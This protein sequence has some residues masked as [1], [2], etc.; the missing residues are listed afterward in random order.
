MTEQQE[1]TDGVAPSAAYVDIRHALKREL[2]AMLHAVSVAAS[3][4]ANNDLSDLIHECRK[5][6]RKWRAW[7]QLLPK[8]HAYVRRLDRCLRMARLSLGNTRDSAVRLNLLEKLAADQAAPKAVWQRLKTETPGVTGAGEVEALRHFLALLAPGEDMLDQ[9]PKPGTALLFEQLLGGYGRT[10]RRWK[11]AAAKP[12]VRALHDWRKKV[13]QFK[14]Q[15][16]F[17]DPAVQAEPKAGK[18]LAALSDRLGDDHDL[19]LLERSLR[20]RLFPSEVLEAID[21][22]R[23]RLQQDAFVLG[24]Q[25]FAHPTPPFRHLTN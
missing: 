10:R 16:L 5:N 4:P 14:Y 19:A 6:C 3:G 18:R 8:S 1:N 9:L 25:L 7:L 20:D 24:T 15:L 2:P 11:T 22:K 21:R 23:Q 17:L 13:Q 12:S